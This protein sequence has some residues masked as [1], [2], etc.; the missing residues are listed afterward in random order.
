MSLQDVKLALQRNWY[1]PTQLLSSYAV[2]KENVTFT[3]TDNAAYV[4][5]TFAPNQP[6]PHTAGRVNIGKDLVAGWYYIDLFY[7]SNT[8]DAQAATDYELIRARYHSGEDL[9]YNGQSVRIMSCGRTSGSV[10]DNSWFKVRVKVM[11]EA[12]TLR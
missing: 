12:Q 8:G 9:T 7:P 5:L 2:A 1:L 3:P 6:I 11:F 10:L 4:Q